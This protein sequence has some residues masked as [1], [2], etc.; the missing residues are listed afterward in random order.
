LEDRFKRNID[1]LRI[2]VTDR[3]N[4]KCAYC[5]ATGNPEYVPHHEILTFE[6]ILLVARAAVA[7][8][9]KKIRLTGGEPLVRKDIVRLIEYLSRIEGLKD[10]SLTTNG[11][12]LKDLSKELYRAGLRRINISL[13]TL[14]P[15]RYRRITGGGDLKQVLSGIEAA[16]T[17]G[18]DPVKINAV[19]LDEEVEAD[20]DAFIKLVYEKPVHVRFIE[21]MDFDD[22][23]GTRSNLKCSTV[24]EMLSSKVELE[25][26]E[27]PIGYGPANYVRP[28]GALGTIG[29]ICPYSRHFCE[30]CNRLRLAADGK[31]R[32]CL[33]SDI[34]IDLKPLLRSSEASVE[35][36]V[37]KIRQ[38]LEI[39]PESFKQAIKKHKRSM[40]QVG[41]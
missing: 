39:K 23:C 7:S 16:L 32:P 24:I 27:G 22:D 36:I 21:K 29:F 28:R 5:V 25:E 41:G 34:E 12:L 8:G 14:D 20:L 35:A 10:L 31:L 3:C 15:V 9:I 30:R 6:E 13:D 33:F 17:T 26:T 2:S 19:L 38:A 18:F 37:E 4:L 1:Y 11:L 40:R